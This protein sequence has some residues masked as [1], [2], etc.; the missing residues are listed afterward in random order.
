MPPKKSSESGEKAKNQT[1]MD[2]FRQN[3]D[4]STKINKSKGISG[5]S[6]TSKSKELI[7]SLKCIENIQNV[8]D[9]K[10]SLLIMAKAIESLSCDQETSKSTLDNLTNDIDDLSEHVNYQLTSLEDN[11][12]AH[13]NDSEDKLM[14]LKV[15]TDIRYSKH[16]L[17]I[18]VRDDKRMKDV[19]RINAIAE[20]TKI[21]NELKLSLGSS[22]IVSG[23]TRFEKR[24][25][26]GPAR[27]IKHIVVTFNDFVT[28][29]RILSDFLMMK[30]KNTKDSANKDGQNT[31][32]SSSLNDK[33][34]LEIPSTYEMRKIM[35]VCREL[36]NEEDI[37][38]IV[39][40]PESVKAIMKRK[41][42]D[43]T[44]EIPKKYEV[45]NFTQIDNMRKKFNMKFSDIPSKQ[46]YTKEYWQKKND[47][48]KK[49]TGKR[50]RGKS[51]EY[52]SEAKRDRIDIR[53]TPTQ[54]LDSSMESFKEIDE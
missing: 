17:K 32:A 36:K 50:K 20:A 54:S 39:Y 53:G 33:Y 51:L 3:Q 34:Y 40:G 12:A 23:E 22:K 31:F 48:Y 9:V 49:G 25:L 29:E 46:I 4:K 42:K 21:L 43:D 11:L 6:N 44:N 13:K 52:N 10:A 41:N 26:F 18:F 15:A 7:E 8:E 35:S 16:F 45:R 5:S 28:A 37:E 47:S 24:N 30:K 19:T 38:K 2:A 27:F 1:I 14:A